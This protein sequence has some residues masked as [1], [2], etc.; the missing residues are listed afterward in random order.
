[1]SADDIK[2]AFI[3]AAF[4]VSLISLYLTRLNW[5]QSNRPLVTA[6]I[7]EHHSGNSATVFNLVVSNTGNRP[8]VRVRLLAPHVAIMRLVEPGTSASRRASLENCFQHDSEIPLLRNGEELVTSF[9]AC[10]ETA[11]N[12]KWLCYGAEIDIRV[13]YYDLDGHKFISQQ[14]LKIY[15]R[16]GFG[17]G[18]W[19]DA[20]K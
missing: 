7:A 5:R 10:G 9:G 20:S 3:A 14:P 18:V 16:T 1:M 11:L 19:G 12:G 8:A 17:G 2:T 4:V 15:T 6:F 13:T